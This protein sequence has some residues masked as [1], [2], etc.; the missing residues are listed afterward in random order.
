M[1][2]GIALALSEIPL[3]LMK[4]ERLA[5]CVYQRGGEFEVQF[6][7]SEPNRV[8]PVWLNGRLQILRWGNRRDQSRVLPCTAWSRL[9][10]LEEGGWGERAE[11]VI[12]PASLV[13]DG[14]VWFW[15]REGIRGVIAEDERRQTV[16]YPLLEPATHYYQI[17]TRSDW[18]P[19]LINEVI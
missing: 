13:L 1:L 12:I 7:L 19:S 4:Q 6:L 16:V 5:R 3:E 9:S 10:T 2:A 18:A 11:T 15:I 8:L 14:K 17:M